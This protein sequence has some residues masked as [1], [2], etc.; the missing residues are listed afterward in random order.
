MIKT[1]P[2]LTKEKDDVSLQNEIIPHKTNRID[3][4]KQNRFLRRSATKRQQKKSKE[5]NYL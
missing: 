3:K 5:A 4:K 1:A 2:E